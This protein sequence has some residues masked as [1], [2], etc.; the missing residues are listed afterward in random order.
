[1][2]IICTAFKL[3]QLENMKLFCTW[4]LVYFPNTYYVSMCSESKCIYCNHEKIRLC[5][6]NN[7][8]VFGK[9]DRVTPDFFFPVSTDWDSISFRIRNIFEKYVQRQGI[10]WKL[11][12]KEIVFPFSQDKLKI[13]F[14][15]AVEHSFLFCWSVVV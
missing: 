1:M 7:K 14:V 9:T 15:H 3:L 6:F 13:Y 11:R 8:Y 10:S 4:R 5:D 2:E 12:V